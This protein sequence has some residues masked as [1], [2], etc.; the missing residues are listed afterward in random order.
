LRAGHHVP[1]RQGARSRPARVLAGVTRRTTGALHPGRDGDERCGGVA[2][3]LH[4]D[5]SL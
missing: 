5:F 3:K 1:P 2:A 4:C